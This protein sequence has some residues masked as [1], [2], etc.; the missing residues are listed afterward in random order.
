MTNLKNFLITFI[1]LTSQAFATTNTECNRVLA[2]PVEP[3]LSHETLMTYGSGEVRYLDGCAI[4]TN[5]HLLKNYCNTNITGLI[6]NMERDRSAPIP[7]PKDSHSRFSLSARSE[8]TEDFVVQIDEHWG[9]EQGGSEMTFHHLLPVRFVRGSWKDYLA[10]R[11]VELEVTEEGALKASRNLQDISDLDQLLKQLAVKKSSIVKIKQNLF[12]G[13]NL[14]DEEEDQ[15]L[16]VI[17][18]F[19]QFAESRYEFFLATP[20]VYIQLKGT[21]S[22][23]TIHYLNDVTIHALEI[24][25]Q[26]SGLNT[27]RSTQ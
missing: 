4:S 8:I 25:D 6:R 9:K 12:A 16:D 1:A 20:A 15:F 26:N 24:V 5:H 14:P 10:G 22:D 13:F 27:E 2:G 7:Y 23:M 17:R 21:M 19:T 3:F 11:Y 18:A